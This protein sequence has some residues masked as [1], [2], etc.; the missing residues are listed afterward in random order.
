MILTKL[1]EIT[2]KYIGLEV[3]KAVI[4]VPAYFSDSQRQATRDSGRIAGLE[5]LRLINEP[6]AAA[7]AFRLDE[8][9]M[10]ELHVL[11][12]DL[13]GGTFDV[14]LLAIEE[15][16]FEILATSG[17]THLGGQDFDNRMVEHLLYKFKKKH[18]IDVFNNQRAIRRLRNC[19]E[20]AKRILSSS[21][22][23]TIELDAFNEGID[24]HTHITR[25]EFEV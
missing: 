3:N 11:I 1:K 25:V 4:A 8:Y 20:R 17:N 2:E 10:E 18:N 22:Q 16:I 19:C 24:F 12:F 5:V 13:G 23:T 6:T 9:T 15:R 14:S 21:I 7:I